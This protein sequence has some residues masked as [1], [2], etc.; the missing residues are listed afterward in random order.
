[1][2]VGEL[3]MFLLIS[4]FVALT[5][6]NVMFEL[7]KQCGTITTGITNRITKENTRQNVK[8]LL[9]AYINLAGTCAASHLR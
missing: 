3:I 8:S 9:V 4:L 5:E 7:R 2:K 6:R 1:M